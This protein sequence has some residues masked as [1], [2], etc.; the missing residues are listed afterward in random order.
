MQTADFFTKWLKDLA[1]EQEPSGRAA[2]MILSPESGMHIG[3]KSIDFLKGAA[4]WGDAAVI[5]PWTLYRI[6]SDQRILPS[7][8]ACVEYERHQAQD[9]YTPQ[10]NT[11]TRYLEREPL[12][13]ACYLWDTN[14]HW[15]EWLEPDDPVPG[16]LFADNWTP[17]DR[18]IL[19]APHIATAYFAYSTHLLAETARVLGNEKDA[20]E[21]SALHQ[22]IKEAYIT[23]FVSSDGR[24]T[25]HK[26]ATYVQARDCAWRPWL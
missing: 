3:N 8:K 12:P 10:G 7:M 25:P 26:Q 19:S 5:V 6:F 16:L 24:M 11:A 9:K 13:H 23:E 20:Q 15:G 1:A 21:Y 18:Q 17:E 22:R 14:Y 2:N 4:G